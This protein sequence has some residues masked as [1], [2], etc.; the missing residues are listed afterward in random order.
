MKKNRTSIIIIFVLTIIVSFLIFKSI[1]SSKEDSSQKFAI[2]DTASV[3]K[4]FIA[5]KNNNCVNLRKNNPGAWIVNDTFNASKDIIDLLLKTM[6]SLDVKQPVSKSGRQQIM[7]LLATNS[8]KVEVYQKVYRIDLFDKI[9]WFPHEKLTKTYYVGGATQ[10]N[11]GTYM[12]IEGSEN[13]CIVYIQGFN[14]FLYTR[15]SPLLKDWRD[16]TVFNLKYNQIKAIDVDIA[17]NP[18][19][20]FRAVKKTPRDYE[21]SMLLDKSK[22][23]NYDTLKLMDL[24]A[25]FENIR[26]E[27]LLN[28]LDKSIK[29]TLVKSKP[30]IVIDVEMVDGS[31]ISVKTYLMKAPP[32]QIDELGNEIIYDRDRLYA[33]IN[34]NKDLVVIQFYVFGRLFKP[35]SY[36]LYG[37]KEE[38]SKLG[39]FEIIN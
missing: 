14:G 26:F 9:K 20:S 33:L 32:S 28:D 6:M 34:N 11:L 21:I 30:Y 36:Y 5:D 13:P 31:K 29:D 23:I 12:L 19:G 22:E 8:V 17:D 27:S 39:N 35:L 38:P 7:K 2:D 1:W 15:Y 16:H 10:D 4:V 3:T 24:F 25:S 18:E 37:A